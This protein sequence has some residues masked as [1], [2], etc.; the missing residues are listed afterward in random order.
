MPKDPQLQSWWQ[1]HGAETFPKE[2][3]SSLLDLPL[4]EPYASQ[5]QRSGL[6]KAAPYVELAP[7][8]LR[9]FTVADESTRR[10]MVEAAALVTT[11]AVTD[12]HEFSIEI[13]AG[14]IERDHANRYL[15]SKLSEKGRES[16]IATLVDSLVTVQ[17]TPPREQLRQSLDA[18]LSGLRPA[19]G[20]RIAEVAASTLGHFD[21]D[22]NGRRTCDCA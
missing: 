16:L 5:L 21:V 17:G 22:G 19:A 11:L 8:G 7:T 20:N 2:A 3:R 10:L 12:L 14:L 4:F 13:V 18:W 6:S 15:L 9:A 1:K